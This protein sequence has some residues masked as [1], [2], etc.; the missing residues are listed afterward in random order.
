LGGIGGVC[1]GGG[2]VNENATRGDWISFQKGVFLINR[3]VLVY[4]RG[5]K[6]K[7]KRQLNE[8]RGSTMRSLKRKKTKA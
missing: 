3:T 1:G 7:A 4:V 6:K 5:K 2:G 8:T